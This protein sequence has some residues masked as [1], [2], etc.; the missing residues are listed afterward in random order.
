MKTLTLTYAR[1]FFVLAA[2]LLLASCA[3][4]PGDV[5]RSPG[6]GTGCMIISWGDQAK[7]VGLFGTFRTSSA[8]FR[9]M[10]D[11]QFGA[12][13]YSPKALLQ[14]GL[15]F[16]TPTD[17]GRVQV[18]YLQPG[19]YVLSNPEINSISGPVTYTKRPTRQVDIPFKIQANRC[20]YLGRFILQSNSDSF[21][22]TSALGADLALIRSEVV[23]MDLDKLDAIAPYPVLPYIITNEP[24]S[25]G[26]GKDA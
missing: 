20:V 10:G 21:L 2:S 17:H 6:Q 16:D 4:L 5:G 7:D 22:W 8:Y 18:R 26:T 9:R 12:L 3:T 13:S 19:A 14:P 25:R 1:L 11:A 23:G 15:A 24:G